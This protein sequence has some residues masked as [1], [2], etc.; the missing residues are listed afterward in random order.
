VHRF[1]WL[2]TI[3]F[4]MNWFGVCSVSGVNGFGAYIALTKIDY[5]S[6]KIT[7]PMAPTILIILMSFLI[8]KSFLAIFSFSMDAILQAF[9][10]DESLGFSGQAR[11]DYILS[12]KTNLEKNARPVKQ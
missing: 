9:L 3:G 1:G 10:F 6:D 4:V 5:F 11:P 12:F 2:N 7:Q 8:V